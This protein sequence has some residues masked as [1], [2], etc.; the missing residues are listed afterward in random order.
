MQ[1]WQ[2]WEAFRWGLGE[3]AVCPTQ[4]QIGG[5]DA[6]LPHGVRAGRGSPLRG[7]LSLR[8]YIQGSHS[9]WGNGTLLP[10]SQ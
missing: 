9:V 8:R 2:A 5:E 6:Q 3:V 1:G 10:L 4:I 7:N